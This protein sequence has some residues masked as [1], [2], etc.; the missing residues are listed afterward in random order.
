VCRFNRH[1]QRF[2]THRACVAER[3]RER[4]REHYRQKYRRD[5]AFRGAEQTRCREALQRR[6]KQRADNTDTSGPESLPAHN[7]ELVT[8]AL[9]SQMIDSRD[10]IEVFRTV[11]RLEHR[12]RRLAVAA[13][14]PRGSPV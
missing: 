14:S 4:A 1:H 3:H 9:V 11:R 13:G 8:A 2:C 12:G 7:I 5:T 10:P 6:R